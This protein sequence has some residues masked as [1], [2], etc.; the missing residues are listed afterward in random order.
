[1]E[2]FLGDI[3]IPEFAEA[4]AMVMEEQHGYIDKF[5]VLKTITD[6]V[7]YHFVHRIIQF[8][9]GPSGD[10]WVLFAFD[11]SGVIY[12]EVVADLSISDDEI[13]EPV[14]RAVELKGGRP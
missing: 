10:I 12:T 11:H 14:K 8:E 4:F 9:P 13:E 3:N 6:P 2:R 1:M 5:D 7:H